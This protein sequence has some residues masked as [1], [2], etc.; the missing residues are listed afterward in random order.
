MSAFKYSKLSEDDKKELQGVYKNID[1][2]WDFS[3]KANEKLFIHI[4]GER[5][6]I[7]YWKKFTS[8]FDRDILRLIH[9][10]DYEVK[11]DLIANVFLDKSLY[12]K[13]L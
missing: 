11:G 9:A 5:M 6:G 1:K 13:A 8:D 7:H 2:I 3:C 4:F 12:A 10:T